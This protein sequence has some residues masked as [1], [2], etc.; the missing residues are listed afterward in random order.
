[1]TYRC[2]PSAAN[3]KCT[4]AAVMLDGPTPVTSAS[5]RPDPEVA[6]GGGWI[7][8]RSCRDPLALRRAHRL[9]FL[10]RFG[11]SGQSVEE[12][13]SRAAPKEHTHPSAAIV[14]TFRTTHRRPQGRAI[15]I[16]TW[17]RSLMPGVL[18]T[19]CGYC[20]L[21]AF[22]HCGRR[23]LLE[24]VLELFP[25]VVSALSGDWL[26]R[27]NEDNAS[28][29]RALCGVAPELQNASHE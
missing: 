2:Q 4:V 27:F 12:L 1:M 10:E 29:K 19:R 18:Q 9:E 5:P 8:Q 20:P 21:G 28:R 26:Q 24:P 23:R 14:G 11:Q 6:K 7:E 25:A 13:A 16:E 17:T 22:S 15:H 3:S